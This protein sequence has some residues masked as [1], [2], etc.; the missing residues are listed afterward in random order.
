MGDSEEAGGAALEGALEGLDGMDP[1]R[2][3][4]I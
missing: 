2:T 1:F 3:P 4:A